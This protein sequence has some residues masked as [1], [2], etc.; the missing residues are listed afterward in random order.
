[1]KFPVDNQS[2]AWFN[3]GVDEKNMTLAVDWDWRDLTGRYWSEKF[4]GCRGYWQASTREFWT[5]GG[6]HI[7]VPAHWKRF[8][9]NTDLDG[10]IWAGHCEIETVASV[11][12]RTGEW[13]DEIVFKVF[14]APLL[15]GDWAQRMVKVKPLLR[16]IDFASAVEFGIVQRGEDPSTIAAK[17]IA[18]GG[19]GAMFRTP[20]VT[21]YQQQR[22]INLMRI[23]ERN[24]YA[25][26]RKESRSRPT[27]GRNGEDGVLDITE[28]RRRHHERQQAMAHAR[29]VAGLDVRL[30]PFDPEID[31][32]IRL[33][34]GD[35]DF[36]ELTKF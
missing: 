26:W 34:L 36:H 8:M 18:N 20:G 29:P 24:L 13:T 11:A 14:D 19:E 10:E 9:P 3:R 30:F 4:R 21:R 7:P 17:I 5:R 32:N 31:W 23:K 25:P 2:R 28:Q 27:E 35:D 22:T 6:N 12:V 33:A 16:G 1:L 15:A